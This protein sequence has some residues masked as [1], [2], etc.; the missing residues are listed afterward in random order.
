MNPFLRDV[1]LWLV[2]NLLALQPTPFRITLHRGLPFHD[3][4]TV[5]DPQFQQPLVGIRALRSARLRVEIN[6]DH[7]TVSVGTPDPSLP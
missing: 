4:L 1:D 7:D 3:F 5:P 2:S 6:F